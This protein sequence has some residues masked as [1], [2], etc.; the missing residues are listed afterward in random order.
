M[1]NCCGDSKEKKIAMYE[2]RLYALCM[3]YEFNITVNQ[4]ITF[5][6]LFRRENCNELGQVFNEESAKV[7]IMEFR[8]F[9]FLVGAE[10]ARIRRSYGFNK[11]NPRNFNDGSKTVAYECP[12]NASPY[13]D[14]VWR[15]MI[16]YDSKYKDMCYKICYGYLMRKDPRQNPG[17]ALQ[18]YI[19]CRLD[20]YKRRIKLYPFHNCWPEYSN[21]TEYYNDFIYTV[22]ASPSN[23][24][25]FTQYLATVPVHQGQISAQMCISKSQKIKSDYQRQFPPE[26]QGRPSHNAQKINMAPLIAHDHL[27]NQ[28]ANWRYQA[29]QKI[30]SGA[31]PFKFDE[32]V[33]QELM[34]SIDQAIDM[35]FEYRRFILLYGLTGYKLY[36]SEQIEKVWLIHMAHGTNYI[37]F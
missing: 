37:K 23:V 4:I 31:L 9:M 29:L 14:R 26:C 35:I 1:G 19:E 25:N 10:L 30:M 22:W 21:E 36:P 2:A 15:A 6:E 28:D 13:I 16:A 18:R 5:N 20:C 11:L 8:K 27:K 17:A 32:F 24:Q 34:I 33:A 7:I 3:K 12:Y